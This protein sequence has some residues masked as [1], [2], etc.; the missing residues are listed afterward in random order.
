MYHMHIHLSGRLYTCATVSLSQ[1][2]AS[3][4]MN[5]TKS[6]DVLARKT[7][8]AYCDSQDLSRKILITLQKVQNTDKE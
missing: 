5:E 4:D 7:P 2:A 8:V 3:H 1:K 6:G